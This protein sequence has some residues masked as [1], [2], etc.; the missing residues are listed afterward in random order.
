MHTETIIKSD[1]EPPILG[2]V[3]QSVIHSGE[4]AGLSP[5]WDI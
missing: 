1:V 3:T 2:E 4:F 5:D